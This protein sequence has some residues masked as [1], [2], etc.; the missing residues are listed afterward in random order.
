[1]ATRVISV[2]D[3]ARAM[4]SNPRAL[5]PVSSGLLTSELLE[6]LQKFGAVHRSDG[7]ALPHA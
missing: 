7:P 3:F 4:D 2:E 5:E 1:M 6:L